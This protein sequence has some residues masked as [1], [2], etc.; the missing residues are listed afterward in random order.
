MLKAWFHLACGNWNVLNQLEGQT[1]KSGEV[2][3]QAKLLLERAESYLTERK[4]ALEQSEFDLGS[5]VEY[6]KLA[7]AVAKA[8]NLKDQGKAMDEKLKASSAAD[9]LKAEITARAAYFK[10]APMQCS[11]KKTERD[12]AKAG[13]EQLAK[14]FGDTAFGQQA[15]QAIIVMEEP[16]AH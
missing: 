7:V 3:E 2:G 5:Y 11:N 15:K 10:I 1:K 12:N 13:Y 8:P 6:K 14:K 9:P 16:A 4:S